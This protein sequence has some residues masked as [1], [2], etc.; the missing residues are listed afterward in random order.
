MIKKIITSI[1]LVLLL[2]IVVAAVV[3]LRQGFFSDQQRLI[4]LVKGYGMIGPILFLLIQ[5]IQVVL[6]IIPGGISCLAGVLAF[7]ALKGFILNYIGICIGSVFAF[8]LS[9]RYGRRVIENLFDHEQIAKYDDKTRSKTFNMFF[10]FAIFF[11]FAPDDLLCYLAGTT[12]M[13]FNS[14]LCIILFCK[15]FSIF[16]YSLFL[17]IGWDKALSFFGG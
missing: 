16:L 12:R 14:F 3:F 8:L 17:Q 13:S 6:P 1:S 10:A 4:D 9:R 11:P 15:P 5:I 2:A 7:G